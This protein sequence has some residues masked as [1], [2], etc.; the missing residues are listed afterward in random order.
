MISAVYKE[1]LIGVAV[2]EA[3][4]VKIWHI[5]LEFYITTAFYIDSFISGLT[6][7]E[8]YLLKLGNCVALSQTILKY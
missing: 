3:H 6:I 4:C 8:E 7:L 5:F 2:D 1:R